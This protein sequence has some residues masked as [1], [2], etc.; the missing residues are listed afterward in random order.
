MPQAFNY[1]I[2]LSDI[3]DYIRIVSDVLAWMTEW[4]LCCGWLTWNQGNVMFFV[5]LHIIQIFFW[6]VPSWFVRVGREGGV[7]LGVCCSM[8]YY[9]VWR[10]R[11]S[12]D[13]SL[14]HHLSYRVGFVRSNVRLTGLLCCSSSVPHFFCIV[15]KNYYLKA[16][17]FDFCTERRF[18]L[19]E[20]ATDKLCVRF[21]S[22]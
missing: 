17:Y 5:F 22:V 13:C 11:R 18:I 10:R 16:F 19:D 20:W 3:K 7:R 12:N 6:F 1:T 2:P 14:A 8:Q 21:D 4:C 15:L 9:W